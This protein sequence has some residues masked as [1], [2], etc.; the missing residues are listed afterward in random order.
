MSALCTGLQ[1]RMTALTSK[2]DFGRHEPF[3][4]PRSPTCGAETDIYSRMRS[5]SCSRSDMRSSLPLRPLPQCLSRQSFPSSHS[6]C[7]IDPTSCL[8]SHCDRPFKSR[9]A[10]PPPPASGWLLFEI[11]RLDRWTS[12]SLWHSRAGV[13]PPVGRHWRIFRDDRGCFVA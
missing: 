9:R 6:V 8:P 13:H 1:I 11:R 10:P 7:L 3:V 5:A 2:R 12:V 4:C